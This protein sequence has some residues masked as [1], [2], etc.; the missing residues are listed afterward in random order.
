MSGSRRGF[1]R[2]LSFGFALGLGAALLQSA[3]VTGSAQEEGGGVLVLRVTGAIGPAATD[4]VQRGIR[5]A[6]ARGAELIVIEMDTPGGLDTSM[7][8][9]IQEIIAS[10]VPVAAFVYPSGARAASAGTYILYASHIAAM[11]PATNLGAAT[12]VQIA[13][14]PGGEP[15]R[16]GKGRGEDGEQG[17]PAPDA[18]ER[19][20]VNDAVAYIRGLAHMRGRNADWAERAVREGVSLSAA[21]A[22]REG[23]VDLVADDL[24]AL[25]AALDGRTVEAMG[26]ERVL[27]T[28]NL[29]VHPLEPDWRSRLLAVITDPNI[30]YILMLVGIYGLIYE[31]ASPGMIFPGVV[32]TIS[33]LLALFAF[34][35]L[36]IN[37]AG[38]ALM[39]LGIAFMIGEFLLPSFGALGI[40]GVIA[41]V[42]GSIMLLDTGV[43]GYGVSV[44]LV[45]FFALLSAVFFIF[46]IGM[47]FKSRKR[48]VVSGMEELIGS[49]VEVV[50]DFAGEG[51]VR[52]HS[53][54]WNARSAAPLRRGDRVRV[55]AV[56]G[57][58]LVVG[59]AREPAQEK[60]D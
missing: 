43:P 27:A 42:I 48:P 49:E 2:L 7:R 46:I 1:L 40:G 60:E 36:P 4:Y 26:V 53:E 54:L 23:V 57:L 12:P 9:I 18:M 30:A 39:V 3:P 58:V 24:A 16:D 22:L 6:H 31:L 34:Q 19:K 32:G 15:P 45:A 51:H 56:D 28:R 35:V 13:G 20:I 52:V 33:L 11:A 41:F 21:E 44:P 29:A 17:A 25:L 10:P 5:R 8:A 55:S 14:F 47:V 37:Y 50:E 59:P 38:L